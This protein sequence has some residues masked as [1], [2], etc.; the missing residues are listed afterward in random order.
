MI[1]AIK[2][3]LNRISGV[4]GA[5]FKNLSMD[6]LQEFVQHFDF[7]SPLVRL[8]PIENILG[9]VMDSGAIRYDGTFNIY[10]LTKFESDNNSEDLRDLLIENML[11]LSEQFISRLNK[12]EMLYFINPKWQWKWKIIRQITSNLL[13]GVMVSINL[14][15]SCN[16]NAIQAGLDANLNTPVN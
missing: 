7:A 16:R 14:D 6:E 9:N 1:N 3:E 10:F 12:N 11:F 8:E 2:L 13:C 4:L 5:E 15:T